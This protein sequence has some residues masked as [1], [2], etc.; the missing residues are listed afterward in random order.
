[1]KIAFYLLLKVSVI[2][3]KIFLKVQ[4]IVDNLIKCTRR[5]VSP[6][7]TKFDF[8]TKMS[9]K[10]RRTRRYILSCYKKYLKFFKKNPQFKRAFERLPTLIVLTIISFTLMDFLGLEKILHDHLKELSI[11]AAIFLDAGGNTSGQVIADLFSEGIESDNLRFIQRMIQESTSGLINGIIMGVVFAFISLFRSKGLKFAMAGGFSFFIVV[12][13]GNLISVILPHL[14]SALGIDPK[15]LTGPA[16]TTIMDL[17]S[18]VSLLTTGAIFMKPLLIQSIWIFPVVIILLIISA[19]GLTYFL[20]GRMHSVSSSDLEIKDQKDD[21]ND[22]QVYT[23]YIENIG[24]DDKY[25]YD[26]YSHNS[27]LKLAKKNSFSPLQY[28]IIVLRFYAGRSYK[29]VCSILKISRDECIT[30]LSETFRLLNIFG[31]LYDRELKLSNLLELNFAAQT[32]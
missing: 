21:I 6:L 16:A 19:F 26:F 31:S 18:H 20:Q 3:E 11:S 32:N 24:I 8:E 2:V 13:L 4:K 15:L 14:S 27:L 10:P 23:N 17:I 25:K 12:F 7:G 29:E 30:N 22:I 9:S 28:S 5:S 1:M